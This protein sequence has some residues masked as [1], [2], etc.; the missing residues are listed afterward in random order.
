MQLLKKIQVR[1]SFLGNIKQRETKV[2][3]ARSDFLK[4]SEDLY[5]TGPAH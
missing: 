3:T 4:I 1:E 5:R 2:S